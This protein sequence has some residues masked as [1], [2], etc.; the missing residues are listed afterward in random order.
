MT[1]NV[2]IQILLS[3]SS[4]CRTA[5]YS[6]YIHITEFFIM[7]SVALSV[8]VT[9]CLIGLLCE[10]FTCKTYNVGTYTVSV[11]V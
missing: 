6:L 4:L 7:P 5:K 3:A 10:L 11:Y 9:F 1:S 2:L 8:A